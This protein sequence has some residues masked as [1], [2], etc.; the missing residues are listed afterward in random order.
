[1]QTRA[2]IAWPVNSMKYQTIT[3]TPTCS[4]LDHRVIVVG[5]PFYLLRM[6]SSNNVAK[7]GFNVLH[8]F[9]VLLAELL[10]DMLGVV[11]KY[12]VT[13]KELTLLFSKLKLIEDK[14]VCCCR[15]IK[16]H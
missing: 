3:C 4:I 7:F 14:W 6:L 5:P 2:S 16:Y 8:D 11:A 15:T 9:A 10:V 13:V 1:M 12:S